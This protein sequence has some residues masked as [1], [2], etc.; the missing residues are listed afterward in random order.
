MHHRD[1]EDTEKKNKLGIRA[2][3]F[4]VLFLR[5]LRELRG[6]FPQL[7]FCCLRTPCLCGNLEDE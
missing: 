6:N 5:V 7:S 3:G 2:L 1:T 4:G